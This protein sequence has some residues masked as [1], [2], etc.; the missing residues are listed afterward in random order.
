M[1]GPTVSCLSNRSGCQQALET[2][3]VGGW[4]DAGQKLKWMDVF[5]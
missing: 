1:Y 4:I 5:K 3:G 2:F